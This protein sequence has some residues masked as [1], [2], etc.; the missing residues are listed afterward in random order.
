[1]SAGKNT[2]QR[3]RRKIKRS[4]AAALFT[5]RITR[6]YQFLRVFHVHVINNAPDT[7]KTRSWYFRSVRRVEKR[8]QRKTNRR[9]VFTI[10]IQI[11]I[12]EPF[13]IHFRTRETENPIFT[14]WLFDSISR[15]SVITTPL[16]DLLMRN[17][18]TSYS[19]YIYYMNRI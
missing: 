10:Q 3:P 13:E 1:V 5:G 19:A 8:F 7:N 11:C 12:V 14:R 16:F 9:N 4:S 15:F 6:T 18:F 2:N 17:I